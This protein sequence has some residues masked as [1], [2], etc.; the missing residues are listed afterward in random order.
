MRVLAAR[1][2]DLKAHLVAA[3]FIGAAATL[4]VRWPVSAKRAWSYGVH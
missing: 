4:S 1:G 3:G 2:I